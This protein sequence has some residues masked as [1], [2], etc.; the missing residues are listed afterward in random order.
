MRHASFAFAALL[1]ATSL[2]TPA[3]A[4]VAVV[5][6]LA[7]LCYEHA[8]NGERSPEAID[9]CTGALISGLSVRDRA[10]TL[11]NR[12]IIHMNRG[13]H[14]RALADF[15]HAIELQP[16]LA[17]GHVNRGAALLA[18]DNYSAAITAINRGLELNPMEPARAYYNRGVAHE[19][20]GQLRAAYNDYR[21]AADMAPTWAPPRTE[22]TRFRVG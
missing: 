4:Y 1:A 12:G 20:L 18:Q 10:A 7:G 11:I 6:G 5:G 21:R 16:N 13:G 15:D 14:D 3:S 8:R 17:E 19:E 2:T 9:N 22:L